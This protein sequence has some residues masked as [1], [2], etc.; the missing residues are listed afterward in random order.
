MW[1]SCPYMVLCQ[2]TTVF[3]CFNQ[4]KDLM[5]REDLMGP[6]LNKSGRN[7]NAD[8]SSPWSRHIS[9][10][11]LMVLHLNPHIYASKSSGKPSE[12]KRE[13]SYKKKKNC[14]IVMQIE[15]GWDVQDSRRCS[16]LIEQI[17]GVTRRW[18]ESSLYKRLRET[19]FRWCGR[20]YK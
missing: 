7:W 12:K 8:T 1:P 20:K 13:G 17:S 11:S 10:W 3:L 5:V 18:W 4:I 9:T 16:R 6:T 15:L 2:H 19:F 14:S